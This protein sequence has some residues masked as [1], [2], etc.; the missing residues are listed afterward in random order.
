MNGCD[1][2]MSGVLILK[3]VY[4]SYISFVFDIKS[5]AAGVTGSSED[6]G[7]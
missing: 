7:R 4:I 6:V 1:L 3:Y 5:A 2:I